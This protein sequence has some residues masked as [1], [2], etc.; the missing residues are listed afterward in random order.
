MPEIY[1]DINVIIAN[2]Q[3][4]VDCVECGPFPIVSLIKAADFRRLGLDE[5]EGYATIKPKEVVWM[6]WIGSRKIHGVDVLEATN[7]FILVDRQTFWDGFSQ[8][9][10]NPSAPHV[11]RFIAQEIA[12]SRETRVGFAQLWSEVHLEEFDDKTSDFCRRNT[13]CKAV[14]RDGVDVSGKRYEVIFSGTNAGTSEFIGN[15][16]KCT[17]GRKK[18]NG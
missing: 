2:Q 18:T 15:I 10:G 1:R 4:A 7:R 14:I 6:N 11:C 9:T 17:L 3:R 5:S 16:I 13:E 8:W 12:S